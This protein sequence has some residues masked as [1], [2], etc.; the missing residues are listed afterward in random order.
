MSTQDSSSN[1]N[2]SLQVINEN[3]NETNLQNTR[4]FYER[5]KGFH[6]TKEGPPQET[7]INHSSI[8]LTKQLFC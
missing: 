5:W 1:L 7:K 8:V 6:E 3:A 2:L 4:D